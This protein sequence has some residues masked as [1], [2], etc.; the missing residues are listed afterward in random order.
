MIVH[1]LPGWLSVAIAAIVVGL[2]GACFAADCIW[3]DYE[4]ERMRWKTARRLTEPRRPGLVVRFFAF[5]AR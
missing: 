3:R 5:L 4:W 2:F 1:D